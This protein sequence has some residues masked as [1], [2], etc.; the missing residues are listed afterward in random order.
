MFVAIIGVQGLGQT[1]MEWSIHYLTGKTKYWSIKHGSIPLVNDPTT[2]INAHAHRKNAPTDLKRLQDF[3]T[4]AKDQ[5]DQT[6]ISCYPH[7][8]AF[9]WVEQFLPQLT[10]MID[11]MKDENFHIFSINL[12]KPYPMLTERTGRIEIESAFS[13][14]K[15]FHKNKLDFD[16][17]NTKRIRETISLRILK[18]KK[19]WLDNV[20]AFYQRNNL[21][22]DGFYTDH[23]WRTQAERCVKEIVSKIGL[24]VDQDRLEKWIPIMKKWQVPHLK[25]VHR[26][27]TELPLIVEHIVHNESLDLRPFNLGILDQSLIMAYLMRDHGRRVMLTSN[28]FPN[29]AKDLHQILN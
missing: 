28:Q 23:E 27:E 12:T 13:L 2:E 6:L 8:N 29:N 16:Q 26:Y 18:N 14:C 20:N 21:I 4:K 1:F 17:T 10:R 24:T 19:D 9:E 22:V 11:Y 5:T 25:M 7:L 15:I 3:V